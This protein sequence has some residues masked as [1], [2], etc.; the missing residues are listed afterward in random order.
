MSIMI[1]NYCYIFF[2]DTL[3][4]PAS[5]YNLV[6]LRHKIPGQTFSSDVRKCFNKSLCNALRNDKI[7]AVDSV[8]TY[9]Y[10]EFFFWRYLF[11]LSPLYHEQW[12]TAYV[13]YD[14]LFTMVIH[15]TLLQKLYKDNTESQ[16]NLSWK[17]AL[18]VIW[19]KSLFK[20]GLTSKQIQQKDMKVNNESPYFWDL[21]DWLRIKLHSYQHTYFGVQ[22]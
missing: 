13:L 19:P 22:V 12:K 1:I 9:C 6:P 5:C 3:S 17:R 16:N 20:L 10:Q 15:N 4:F 8:D 18:E 2:K 21:R 14:T 11:P 7:Q